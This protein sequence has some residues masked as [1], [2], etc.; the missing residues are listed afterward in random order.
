MGWW[1]GEEEE[2]EEVREEEEERIDFS[3]RR[4]GVEGDSEDELQRGY[5][6]VAG[7]ED[8]LGK[9]VVANGV[10]DLRLRSTSTSNGTS[11]GT[12]QPMVQ[13]NS[14]RLAL[15]AMMRGEDL[16]SFSSGGDIFTEIAAA[17]HASSS[18]RENGRVEN[19]QLDYEDAGGVTG[20]V[21][22]V[23]GT[24]HG[25]M[26]ELVLG[27]D[28]D[29]EAYWVP[30][31][32]KSG[33]LFYYNTRTA[34]TSRYMPVDGMGD[35]V[36]IYPDEWAMG[37]EDLPKSSTV[38]TVSDRGDG[39]SPEMESEWIEVFDTDGVTTYYQNLTTGEKVWSKPVPTSTGSTS[40][41]P[42]QR[43]DF[44]PPP[45]NGTSSAIDR[46]AY[47][48]SRDD[49]SVFSSRTER[50]LPTGDT[51]AT[52]FRD[53][54]TAPRESRSDESA[55]EVAG[56]DA[57]IRRERIRG[58]LSSDR[59]RS[60]TVGVGGV[61]PSKPRRRTRGE[62]RFRPPICWNLLRLRFFPNSNR[63]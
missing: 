2:E 19:D 16:N 52:T 62:D 21:S 49:A 6:G 30:K 50:A 60:I 58:S 24:G 22:L 14:Q 38:P 57:K 48:R 40:S 35:G 27:A 42:Q 20:D 1:D 12:S 29:Q 59:R 13:Q 26:G 61:S 41:L 54:Q 34:E 55:A 15:E 4:G 33:M 18:L 11:N 3:K 7:R 10:N 17:A 25:G 43:Q 44:L 36:Q 5:S 23:V 31:V 53:V 56:N 51:D 37:Q 39:S 47:L 63:V 28:E 9:A 46:L 45:R 32:T 8:R